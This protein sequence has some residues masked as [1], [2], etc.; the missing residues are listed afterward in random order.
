MIYIT[1]ILLSL[2]TIIYLIHRGIVGAKKRNYASRG[3]A[4]KQKWWM[5]V[6]RVDKCLF[7]RRNEIEGKIFLIWSVRLR[8]NG[9]EII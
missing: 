7:S 3:H 5:S 9:K 2:I 1:L 4:Y 8:I 6:K